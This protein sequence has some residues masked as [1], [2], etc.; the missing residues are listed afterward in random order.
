MTAHLVHDTIDP[1]RPATTSSH[2]VR[3]ALRGRLGFSGAVVSDDLGMG[4][5]AELS[6]EEKIEL[7]AAAGHDLLCVCHGAEPQLRARARLDAIGGGMDE[8]VGARLAALRRSV[9]RLSGAPATPAEPGGPLAAEIAER[10]LTILR[11]GAAPVAIPAGERWLLILPAARDLTQVEDPLRGEDLATFAERL[12][13]RT[14]LLAVG[15]P[16]TPAEIARAAA[17]S[18]DLDGIVV[19]TIGLRRSDAERQLV[20]GCLEWQP[21]TIV[22]LLGDPAELAA[23]PA[24]TFT[25]VT[26]YGY[27]RV[28]Q[29][30]LVR[31]LRGEIGAPGRYPGPAEVVRAARFDP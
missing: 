22:V 11:R 19:A 23:L 31:L 15:S 20:L 12:A 4:A 16:P 21:R 7:A 1:E 6:T 10:A 9:G 13:D 30:A 27:R 14:E 28:H 8:S 25:A 26:A 3:E 29:E 18:A 17:R 2:V 24:R 5:L